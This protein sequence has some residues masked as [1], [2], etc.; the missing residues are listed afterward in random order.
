MLFDAIFF[1]NSV[2]V[3]VV[4]VTPP[5]MTSRSTETSLLTRFRSEILW[6]K[7]TTIKKGLLCRLSSIQPRLPSVLRRGIHAQNW[8]VATVCGC[9]LSRSS[10]PQAVVVWSTENPPNHLRLFWHGPHQHQRKRLFSRTIFGRVKFLH[11]TLMHGVF[12]KAPLAS[13]KNVHNFRHSGW[14]CPF[15]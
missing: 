2:M 15:T 10:C 4:A 3:V 5:V 13:K 9:R 14:Q 8:Q 6:E 11:V 1:K 12:P 7:A